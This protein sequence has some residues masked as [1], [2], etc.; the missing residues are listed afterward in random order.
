MVPAPGQIT[1]QLACP[2]LWCPR[3]YRMGGHYAWALGCTK[4]GAA[5]M[6]AHPEVADLIDT[7][8]DDGAVPRDWTRLDVRMFRALRPILEP[9]EHWPAAGHLNPEK[10]GPAFWTCGRCGGDIPEALVRL[11]PDPDCPH[12]VLGGIRSDTD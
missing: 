10:L 7:Y 3:P 6:T 4:F 12:C 2:E 8:R 9:H 11:K 5:L 1:E